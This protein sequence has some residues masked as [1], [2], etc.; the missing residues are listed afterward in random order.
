MGERPIR[1]LHQR[2]LHSHE[3]D[4]STERVYRPSSFPFPPS[5]GRTGFELQA[6]N[7]GRR[8]GI[9]AHDG[10]TEERCAWE[11]EENG[12]QRLVLKRPSGDRLVLQ[13][14]SLDQD[15]LVVRR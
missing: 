10:A 6:G 1:F 13:I 14:V 12:E 5:R 9:A 15:R 2:W 3:E 11:L 4:T 8:I 7:V